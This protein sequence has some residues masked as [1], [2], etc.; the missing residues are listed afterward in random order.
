MGLA[1]RVAGGA[2]V[3]ASAL[4]A[5]L[6]GCGGGEPG[7]QGAGA[8][9]GDGNGS[10]GSG[11]ASGSAGSGPATSPRPD[12]AVPVFDDGRIHD[13]QLDMSA[14]DWQSIIQDT[15]G[16]DWRHATLTLDGVALPDVGVRPSGEASRFPGNP[17]QSMRIKFDAFA[18]PGMGKFAGLKE[19]NVKGAY[20]DNSMMRER[21]SL[22]VFAAM[23]PAPKAVHGRLVVNGDL[24]GLYTI[25]EVWDTAAIKARFSEP[26]G[27]LYRL[28][29]PAGMSDPYLYMGPDPIAYVPH[30]WEPHIDMP[31]RGDDVI[32]WFLSGLASAPSMLEQVTDV[33][34]LLSYLAV[35]AVIM[36]TD[37]FAGESGVED[38]FQYF[39]PQSGKFFILPWDPDN[40]FSS[41]GE[42]PDYATIYR[43][44]SRSAL[45][46]AV[47]DAGDYRARYKAKI[48]AVMG[49][50]P[51]DALGAEADRIH[52]QIQATAYEDPV[53]AFPNG[54]FDWSVGYIKDFAA[55]RYANVQDQVVNGP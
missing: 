35:N 37:G 4:I 46:V 32:G 38:H 22:F 12:P 40:T 55:Q 16:D 54:T 39:D 6:W 24:R 7:S 8:A 44:F 21:L 48:M 25:R 11:G 29:P 2:G 41:A 45:G 18:P 9:G 53:K 33:E 34:N 50:V 27:P 1:Y 10:N 28:R 26:V 43:H 30:P 19:I 15:Q 47:R 13:V 49:A 5:L 42:M 3:C 23:M 31:A 51:L 36:N 52:A 14:D 17:K 20:D